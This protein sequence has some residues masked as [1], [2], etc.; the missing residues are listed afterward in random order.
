MDTFINKIIPAASAKLD[1]QEQV[2]RKFSQANLAFLEAI[3]V[4]AELDP[5]IAENLLGMDAS[6][7]QALAS[8]N[9]A[10]IMILSMPGVP[11]MFSRLTTPELLEAIN[12]KEYSDVLFNLMLK[13]FNTPVLVVFH[14]REAW[15]KLAITMLPSW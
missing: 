2:Q 13:N 4:A 14:R 8:M 5:A 15:F 9:K 6:A 3:K 1:A 12:N 10:T 7:L 11:L